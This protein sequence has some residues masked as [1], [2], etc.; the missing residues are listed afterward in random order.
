M[1]LTSF[2]AY[3]LFTSF[4]VLI[5]CTKQEATIPQFKNEPTYRFGSPVYI[6]NGFFRGCK[7]HLFDYSCYDNH[8]KYKMDAD[9]TS[10]N[11]TYNAKKTLEVSEEDLV[12]DGSN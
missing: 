6:P 4:M 7:G 9:C 10:V 12:E 2:M 11:G 3:L 5:S 1:K 8:C